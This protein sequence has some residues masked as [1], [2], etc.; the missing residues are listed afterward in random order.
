MK[1]LLKRLYYTYLHPHPIKTV[2]VRG[3]LSQEEE[4]LFLRSKGGSLVEVVEVGDKRTILEI[5]FGNG[6]HLVD[7]A[8]RN[9]EAQVYGVELYKAGIV[10]VLKEIGQKDLQNL[11]VLC[12]DARDVLDRLKDKTISE[13]YILFPDPWPKVRHHKRRLLQKDFVKKC[14]N[15]LTGDG[16][17]YIATDWENYA[18]EIEKSLMDLSTS[19]VLTYSKLLDSPV[20]DKVQETTFAK[21]AIREG[22]STTVFKITK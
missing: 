13:M 11:K 5:G 14:V 4:E 10:K 12:K 21:R 17:L 8:R 19:K 6:Q 15:I 9:P 7:L 3:R 2:H 20:V 1:S 22:R 16:V 18:D